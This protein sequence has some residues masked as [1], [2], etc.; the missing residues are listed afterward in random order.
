VSPSALPSPILRPGTCVRN[1]FA[2]ASASPSLRKR[3][4]SELSGLEGLPL[5][6]LRKASFKKGTTMLKPFDTSFS[7][8]A[9][10]DEFVQCARLPESRTASRT[11]RAVAQMKKF[12]PRLQCRGLGLCDREMLRIH[13]RE[14]EAARGGLMP[15]LCSSCIALVLTQRA[16]ICMT[17]RLRPSSRG[18]S[19]EWKPCG[20]SC[21]MTSLLPLG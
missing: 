9:L 3:S 12:M 16:G 21:K 2:S 20:K 11:L 6:P 8:G 13:H 4:P 18:H 7:P 17:T 1:A 14:T 19:K 15:L 5:A 10:R